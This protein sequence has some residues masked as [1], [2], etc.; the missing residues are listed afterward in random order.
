MGEKG[1]KQ[2]N[3]VAGYHYSEGR[4]ATLLMLGPYSSILSLYVYV[5]YI[6]PPHPLLSLS[7]L[8][9]SL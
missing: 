9:H 1:V 4:G 6:T 5:M 8:L 2:L 3:A 7:L